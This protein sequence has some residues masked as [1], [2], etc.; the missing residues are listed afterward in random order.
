MGE[1]LV[2]NFLIGKWNLI[3]YVIKKTYLLH[4]L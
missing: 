1:F 3:A 4:D 2:D